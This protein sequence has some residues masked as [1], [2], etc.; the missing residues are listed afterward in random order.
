[1]IALSVYPEV[2]R[3]RSPG[4]RL[5]ALRASSGAPN[6]PGITTSVNRRSIAAPPSMIAIAPSG[7][8][9]EVSEHVGCRSA[10][11][12]I[13]F[14]K[15]YHLGPADECTGGDDAGIVLPQV[16]ARKVDANSR[17]TS[18]LA[19]NLDVAARLFYEATNHGQTKTRPFA[20]R[21][22]SEE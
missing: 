20:G 21:L 19:V 10:H 5:C 2:N 16:R 14:D 4:K 11:G 17:S 13:V 22:G 15:Q 18:E 3:T 8:D 6:A 1:M 12:V 9:T 7:P